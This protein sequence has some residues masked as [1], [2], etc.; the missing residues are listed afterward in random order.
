M[1]KVVLY[2]AMS[3]DGYI[4]DKEGK[5]DWLKGQNAKEENI[6]TY[7]SFIKEVDTVIMGRNTYKQI[8]TELSPN[9]WIYHDLTTYVITHRKL[10]PTENIKFIQE[11]PYDLVKRLKKEQ[12]KKI[13]ICGGGKIVQSLL[14]EKLIDEYNIAVIPVILGAGIPLFGKMLKEIE[15]TLL[16]TL[17]YNG[18]VELLY[19]CR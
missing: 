5:V 11:N 18:I 13:W 2:I 17:T 3:L 16:N 14:K 1:K 8:I 9:Q 7:S 6:D 4:A 10:P 12:G 15:L 19:I